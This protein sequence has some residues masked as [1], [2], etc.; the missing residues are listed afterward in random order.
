MSIHRSLRTDRHAAGL[1]RN[2]TKRFER[3]RHLM[4]EEKWTEGHSVFGL[5]KIKP[6]KLKARKSA[7]KEKEE[8]SAETPSGSS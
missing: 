2:V 8:A 3:I 5:P 7:A 1:L 4:N 6:V